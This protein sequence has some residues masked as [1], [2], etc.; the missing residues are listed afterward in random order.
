MPLLAQED[1]RQSVIDSTFFTKVDS[2]Y[3]ED[4]FYFGFTY[5]ALTNLPNNMAQN[6]FSS[7]LSGGFL[8]DMP[9]NKNRTLAIAIGAGVSYANY[10]QNLVTSETPTGV[11]FEIIN[12][13][14]LTKG[15][16]EQLFIEMPL[17]L[18]W[19]T[20]TPTSYK[21]WRIYGGVK[22]QYLVFDRSR[23]QGDGFDYTVT[24]NANLNRFQYG[25]Y[26]AFGFNTWNFQ[27][28]Y[29]VNSLF[30][31]VTINNEAIETRTLNIGLMFYIL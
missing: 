30:K 12:E 8:R 11:Q 3:R 24:N 9:I 1:E 28:F 21:F 22:L 4:Q 6:N 20:S 29:G 23:F 10:Q 19:R 15:K 16:L 13:N 26:L 31:N 18:R 7:G 17:E 2:L 14:D 25:P 5:N 27:A